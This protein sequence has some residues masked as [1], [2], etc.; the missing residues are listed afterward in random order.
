MKAA[1]DSQTNQPISLE[2]EVQANYLLHPIP[3][4]CHYWYATA[5]FTPVKSTLQ[6]AHFCDKNCLATNQR[7]GVLG[8]LIGVLDVFGIGMEYLLNLVILSQKIVD[9]VC[10]NYESTL[11]KTVH[12][13]VLLWLKSTPT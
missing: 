9:F 8:V 13:C 2:V 11:K 7:T 1:K 10:T 4:I 12:F 6:S 3:D 5:L